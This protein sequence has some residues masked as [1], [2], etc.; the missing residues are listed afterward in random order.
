MSET[1]HSFDE[2]FAALADP[3]SPRWVA[4]FAYLSSRPETA[5]L[6]L[7]TFCETLEHMGVAPSGL[8]PATGEPAYAVTDVAEAMGVPLADLEAASQAASMTGGEGGA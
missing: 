8:D 7:E 1:F 5:A 2:A 3:A 4:A 6:I